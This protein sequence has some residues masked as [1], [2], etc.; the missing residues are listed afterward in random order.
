MSCIKTVCAH[1]SY[2]STSINKKLNLK[3]QISRYI[4]SEPQSFL[5]CYYDACHYNYIRDYQ[6]GH[7]QTYTKLAGTKIN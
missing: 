1:Y 4:N 3:H 2:K 6:L 5:L 7:T